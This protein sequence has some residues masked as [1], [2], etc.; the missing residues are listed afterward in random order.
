MLT[1]QVFNVV[2]QYLERVITLEE[3]EDWLAPR[4]L[5]F[6]KWPYSSLTDFITEI[7]VA[8]AD[9]S[10]QRQTENEFRSLLKNLLEQAQVVWANYPA[11]DVTTYAESS[12]Q[13]SPI[14][15]YVTSELEHAP[16]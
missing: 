2:D 13:A 14:L 1:S 9:M 8:L 11:E 6:F 7:E 5:L 3:L 4:L 10:E 15:Q 16:A 12:N